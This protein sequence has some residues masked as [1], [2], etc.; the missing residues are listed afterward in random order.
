M[1]VACNPTDRGIK[2]KPN[3][4]V[5]LGIKTLMATII[6]EEIQRDPK[7]L[8]ERL[9]SGE[10]LIV[11]EGEEVLAEIMPAKKQRPIGLA[12]GQ[13]VVPDDFDKPMP[14]EFYA[15]LVGKE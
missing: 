4:L 8:V 15:L 6:F 11:T 5:K 9:R 1:E 12:K 3:L 14:D 10:T 13:F 7:G 2:A